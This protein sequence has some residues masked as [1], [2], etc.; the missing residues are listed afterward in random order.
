MFALLAALHYGLPFPLLQ[1]FHPKTRKSTPDR[2][3]VSSIMG[4]GP[5][6]AFF[7]RAE[8]KERKATRRGPGMP[9][10]NKTKNAPYLDI[11]TEMILG[12]AAIGFLWSSL[13][14]IIVEADFMGPSQNANSAPF[15][16]A[17]AAGQVVCVFLAAVFSRRAIHLAQAG[18]T[19]IIGSTLAA[20]AFL[21]LILLESPPQQIT[22]LLGG[23]VG[24]IVGLLWVDM[25]MFL[26]R[27][28][29]PSI[30]VTL[31]VSSM[32]GA[33]LLWLRL[34]LPQPTASVMGVAL[35]PCSMILF[36]YTNRFQD[37]RI[38]VACEA[39]IGTSGDY[40]SAQDSISKFKTLFIVFFVFALVFGVQIGIGSGGDGAVSPYV[41]L[42]FAVPG[43]LLLIVYYGFKRSI[44]FRTLCLVV[45][46][47]A[48]VPLLTWNIDEQM[49]LTLRLF[50]LYAAFTVFDLSA[51]ASLVELGTVDRAP[52]S[53]SLLLGRGF[54]MTGVV[55]GM[56]VA[57]LLD[58]D[59]DAIKIVDSVS[60]IALVVVFALFTLMRQLLSP[61][62]VNHI[63]RPFYDAI[64]F[65][66]AHYGLSKRE[67]EVLILLAKG[68]NSQRIETE[69]T[70]SRNTVKSH[71]SHIYSKLGVHTQQDAIVVV[72]KRVKQIKTG[73]AAEEMTARR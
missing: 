43:P 56:T 31:A 34:E 48:I 21:L 49:A 1:G 11:K 51:I 58:Q 19:A 60:V 66:A 13:W 33:V 53:V 15:T 68:Y 9:S 16:M 61:T 27:T 20:L 46:M 3:R 29:P 24:I 8:L 52:C 18:I 4:H 54:I 37:E 10:G 69:L 73:H 62:S 6:R 71:I 47:A 14:S 25:A 64:D 5:L 63:G 7:H 36:Y 28:D 59:A 57:A 67:G 45:L 55:L 39:L 65:V 2:K 38:K 23:V 22:A 32:I 50:M 70:I 26:S 72:E 17:N 12:I 44:N 30:A 35:V 41:S 42:A 40:Q